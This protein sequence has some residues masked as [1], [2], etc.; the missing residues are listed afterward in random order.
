MKIELSYRHDEGDTC[1]G[2]VTII[3][4]TGTAIGHNFTKQSFSQ[5]IGTISKY[6]RMHE[7][8]WVLT[9]QRTDRE[10]LARMNVPD[11]L[12]RLIKDDPLSAV[13]VMT[14]SQSVVIDT[15][16]CR[17]GKKSDALSLTP[18]TESQ[19]RA[20]LD[21]LADS[22]N[23][24]VFC[25]AKDTRIE[26]PGCGMWPESI[27]EGFHCDRCGLTTVFCKRIKYWALFST[28]ELIKTGMSRYFIPRRWNPWQGFI[29]LEE[30][31]SLYNGWN[32]RKQEHVRQQ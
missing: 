5:V 19:I 6:L 13:R 14:V 17:Q 23:D 21:T 22:I 4:P 29:T 25:R 10:G 24:W 11:E 16:S 12:V 30:L 26:C 15:R 31:A 18:P 8:D 28:P 7:G 32:E 1:S 9:I 20:G 27:G 3:N 2:E